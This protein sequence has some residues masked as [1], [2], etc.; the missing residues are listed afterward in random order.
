VV[1]LDPT[2]GSEI[3]KSRPAVVVNAHIFDLLDT[4]IVVPLT[5]W[6]PRFANQRNKVRV[7]RSPQNGLDGDSA[8]D[9]LQVRCVAV[10]RF[11]ARIGVLEPDLLDEIVAGVAIAIDYQP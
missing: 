8:A 5:T 3:Q 2:V 10:E 7:G 9:F 11:V 4:R 1:S 6:Q